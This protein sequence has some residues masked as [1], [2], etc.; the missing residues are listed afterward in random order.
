MTWTD[1]GAVADIPLRGA[2]R[3]KTAKGCIALFRTGEEEVFAT[4]NT[5][6]HKQGPLAEGIVH[7]RKVTCPLHSWTYSLE[8]GEAQGADEGTIATYPVKIEAGRVLL[9][10][11][12]LAEKAA[13]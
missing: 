3:V 7:G 6:A 12:A 4:S 1:I 10:V 9:D 11:S 2:R 8:T 5:C 13:A